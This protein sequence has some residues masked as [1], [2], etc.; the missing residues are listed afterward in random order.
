[1]PGK[2]TPTAQ[3]AGGTADSNVMMIEENMMM[4][5]EDDGK[6]ASN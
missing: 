4:I 2:E 5:E 6:M 1:M 3:R